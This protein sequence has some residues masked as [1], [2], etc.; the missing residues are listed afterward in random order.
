MAW[1]SGVENAV[2]PWEEEE[3]FDAQEIA[4]VE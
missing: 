3:D 4:E 2:V 1:R